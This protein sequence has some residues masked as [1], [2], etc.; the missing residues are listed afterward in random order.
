M[1][2][3]ETLVVVAWDQDCHRGLTRMYNYL[4]S[5]QLI[6]ISEETPLNRML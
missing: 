2:K 6:E 3:H 5:K 1:I 4:Y